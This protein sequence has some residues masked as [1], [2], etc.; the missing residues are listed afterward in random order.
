MNTQEVLWNTN[1]YI[2]TNKFTRF[3]TMLGHSVCASLSKKDKTGNV[4]VDLGCGTGDHFGFVK[5]ARLIGI[6]RMPKMLDSASLE[7]S[8]YGRVEVLE[9]DFTSKLPFSDN[10]IDS[11]VASGILEHYSIR[12]VET[13]LKEVDRVLKPDGELVVLQVGDGFL[14]ELGRKLTS[15]R[16]AKRHLDVDYDKYLEDTLVRTCKEVLDTVNLFFKEDS[17]VGIP[18][19]LPVKHLNIFIVGR[20]VKYG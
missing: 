2:Y 17:I 7:A 15:D 3:I 10:S 14:Y 1:K 20:Y 6:D 9:A 8:K 12:E 5:K 13:I 16:Y 18:A 11:V 4:I 19:L